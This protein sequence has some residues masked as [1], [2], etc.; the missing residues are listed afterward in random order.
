LEAHGARPLRSYYA[1][2]NSGHLLSYHRSPRY[3]VRAVDFAPHFRSP[4]GTR[5]IY[6]YRDVWFDSPAVARIAGACLN[7]SLFFFW[8]VTL[9]NGRNITGVEVGAF[10]LGELTQDLLTGLPRLFDRLMR[11]YRKH[12]V[13]RRR[14]DCEFQ[15]FRP[16]RSKPLIDAIDRVLARHYGF[17][18]EELDFVLHYE[19]KYRTGKEGRE[20]G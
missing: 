3:W 17:T 20:E 1:N 7:S 12:A 16:A 10:P 5:S 18:A 11:D 19:A 4:R 9:G 14:H 15:E 6:H 2:R 8:F 13:L